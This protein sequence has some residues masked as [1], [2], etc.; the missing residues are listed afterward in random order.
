MRL[1]H[2]LLVAAA[3]VAAVP[4]AAHAEKWVGFAVSDNGPALKII[5]RGP[6][7]LNSDGNFQLTGRFRCIGASCLGHTGV[8][9]AVF[10][11]DAS[12][13]L[14]HETVELSLPNGTTCTSDAD[15]DGAFE[16]L[17]P[18]IGTELKVDYECDDASGNVVDTGSVDITRRR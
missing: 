5:V 16:A 17:P 14:G 12:T 7:V 3:V 15:L 4:I 2:R 18:A 11:N 13:G 1:S 6:A 10:Y 8:A 9:D